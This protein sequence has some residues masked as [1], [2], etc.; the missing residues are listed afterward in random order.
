MVLPMSR[1]CRVIIAKSGGPQTAV[2]KAVS[3]PSSEPSRW[4][5]E[6]GRRL[7]FA[8]IAAVA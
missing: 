3:F 2:V 8:E 5:G 1:D 7:F 6:I 4:E